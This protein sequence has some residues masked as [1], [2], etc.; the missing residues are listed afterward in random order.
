MEANTATVF[1]SRTVA[2]TDFTAANTAQTFQ[3]CGVVPSAG[4]FNP[5]ILLRYKFTGGAQLTWS[6][7]RLYTCTGQQWYRGYLPADMLHETGQSWTSLSWIATTAQ[8]MAFM[9]YGPYDPNL[10]LST[11]MRA[12]VRCR[13]C[14][15]WAGCAG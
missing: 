14:A 15:A 3:L 6:G 12:T 10:P 5:V 7:V 9:I 4:I 8:A 1:T 13:C 2:R 11:T